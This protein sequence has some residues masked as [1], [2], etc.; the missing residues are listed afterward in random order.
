MIQTTVKISIPENV[1]ELIGEIP[2]TEATPEVVDKILAAVATELLACISET[3][4][5]KE[6]SIFFTPMR[7]A[8]TQRIWEFG[9]NDLAKQKTER[10]NFHGQNVSQWVYSG[11]ILLQDGK[12]SRHH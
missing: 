8:G 2:Y 6:P 11:G 7:L 10:Y 3:S 4:L 12:V 9:V 1:R 5:A